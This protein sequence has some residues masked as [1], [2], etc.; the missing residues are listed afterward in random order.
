M[1]IVTTS[2]D[3][4]TQSKTGDAAKRRTGPL[5]TLAYVRPTGLAAMTADT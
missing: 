4:I 5:R 2:A 3:G 1:T